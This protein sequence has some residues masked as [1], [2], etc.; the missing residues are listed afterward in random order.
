MSIQ[1]V[2]LDIVQENTY[3]LG[4]TLDLILQI[5]QEVASQIGDTISVDI[6]DIFNNI[7]STI[8]A[9]LIQDN[10][11]AT[12]YTIPTNLSDLYNIGGADE[13]IYDPSLFYLKDVW[14][15]QDSAL[16]YDIFIKRSSVDVPTPDNCK[17]EINLDG[18]LDID[19]AVLESCDIELT[20][21]LT[22][23]YGNIDSVRSYAQNEL[24]SISNFDI[25][26]DILEWSKY[27]DLHMRPTI[28]TYADSYNNAVREFVNASVARLVLIPI[29]NTNAESKELDTFKISRQSGGAEF[30]IKKL[31]DLIEFYEKIIYAGGLDTP[32]ISKLFTKGLNDPNRPNVS[33][34]SL[35]INDTYP[36]VNTTTSTAVINID[37]QDVEI[38]GV[39]G[40][41]FRSIFRVPPTS[42][43]RLNEISF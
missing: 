27:V 35:M 18:I 30:V 25:A 10:V 14:H 21:K 33:R 4:E 7:I 15:I 34:A 43:T 22:P 3:S 17:I 32:Y 26:T 6:I 37:G 5:D 2:K 23:F 28:I 36:W 11:Y 40:I 12:E 31:D 41:T 24:A 9:E 29:L 20:T 42:M 16:S 38:R 39:R 1:S 8:S 19:S 13:S